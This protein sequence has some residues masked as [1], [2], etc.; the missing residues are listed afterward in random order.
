LIAFNLRDENRVA[1]KVVFPAGLLILS[2]DKLAQN[3][4]LS[5]KTSV[6]IPAL[7]KY[8]VVLAMYCA[9]KHRLSSGSHSYDDVFIISNSATL[10]KLFDLIANKKINIEEYEDSEQT[11]YSVLV[12]KIMDIVWNLTDYDYGLTDSDKDYIAS[13]P[14]SN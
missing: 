5:K 14:D 1:T 6:V 12:D 2:S 7:T 13:L 3:G 4:I 10:Q 9:N 8:R 11:A